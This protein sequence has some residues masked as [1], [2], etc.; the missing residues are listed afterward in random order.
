MNFQHL[1]LNLLRV[2][3]VVM[4]ERNL[5]RAAERLSV[6]QPAVSNALRRLQDTLG[7]DLLTRAATGVAPTPRAEALW[8][9]VRAALGDL[10]R[11]F[12]PDTFDPAVDA[13]SFGIA[14]T[15]G[16]AAM[17]LPRLVRRIAATAPNVDIRVVPL[18]THD[19]R[20][21]LDR[22]DADLAV[23]YFP[24]AAAALQAEGTN[25]N[26][27]RRGLLESNYICV[28]RQGHPLASLPLDLDR[29]CAARHLVASASGRPSG[30]VD[31]ALLAVGRSRR[32]VLTVNQY[33]TAG[34][35]VAESDLLAVLPS[36]FLDATGNRERLL[37]RPLPVE[38]PTLTV[39]MLWHL[40]AEA[41]PAHGWLRD[42]LLGLDACPADA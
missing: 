25:A 27:G 15:D 6:T 40:R 28:M 8:P 5:T 4:V 33:F 2:F 29:Y 35:V 11:A 37:V 26:F 32:V 41:K 14:M 21:L 23:G 3:D 39:S 24:T 31:Q 18:A 16:T 9:E 19:P 30:L 17:L 42:E 34:Q 20:A 10:R 7:E 1:D 13:A 38:L 12:G 22:G 36:A